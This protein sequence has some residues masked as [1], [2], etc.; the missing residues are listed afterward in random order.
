LLTMLYQ[1]LNV[2]M[3]AV[4]MGATATGLYSAAFRSVE[5]SK[6]A[7]LALFAAL[8]PAMASEISL[9]G[10][11]ARGNLLVNEEIAPRRLTA[12]YPTFMIA[13]ATVISLLLFILAKPLV[14]LLYGNE[15][16]SASGVLQ[17]LAWSLVPFTIN[18]YLI[19]SLLASNQERLVGRALTVSLLGLLILNL[20]WIPAR[21]PEGSGWAALIAE[22]IQ[23]VIL[24]AGRRAR[25]FR[26]GTA[27]EFSELS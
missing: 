5:A 7:H 10:L 20:W 23:S 15:F 14:N 9:R 8:Y 11:P 19:L 2:T 13:G 6:T 26:Q 24:F 22:C 21:G 25:V 12:K 16:D 1:R 18:T 17:I 4:M 3:L 27:H